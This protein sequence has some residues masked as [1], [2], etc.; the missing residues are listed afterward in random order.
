MIYV[1][2][3]MISTVLRNLMTNALKFTH[4][5]GNV[6]ISASERDSFIQIDVKDSGIGIDKENIDKV[7]RIDSNMSTTG[8]DEELGTGLGL[9]ISKEFVENNGGTIKVES[10]IGKGSTFT[11]T[12]P[13][14]NG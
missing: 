10:E 6:T 8:T 11:F 5:G 12:V 3:N 9:I 14:Y 13:A 2:T 4:R 1:D 7:F